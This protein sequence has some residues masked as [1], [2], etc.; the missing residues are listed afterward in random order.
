M[1]DPTSGDARIRELVE[2]NPG[3]ATFEEYKI[4]YDVVMRRAPC[5]VLVFG[6][7]RDSPL[8]IDGNQG[9]RTV[10]LEDVSA[11]AA[12]A[13]EHVDQIEVH[14]VRYW[15]RRFMWNVLRYVPSLL[16]MK[17]LPTSVENT[18][19]DVVLVDAPRGT[20]WYR[21]GR[22]MSVHTAAQLTPPGADIFVHDCHRRVER[23]CADHFLDRSNLVEQAGS[24]RHYRK[25]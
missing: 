17:D 10:F 4:V 9:G 23:A 3:Q 5:N 24:M 1:T 7:G 15:T 19:W 14:D 8:W 18:A 2:R 22:M 25:P 21:R 12:Y 6:V 16:R 11:W 13:R 20:R